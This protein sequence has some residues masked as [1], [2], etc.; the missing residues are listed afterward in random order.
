[1]RREF[2]KATTNVGGSTG[3]IIPR[4]ICKAEGIEKGSVVRIIIE[5]VEQR[6]ANLKE[7]A[8]K[9]SSTTAP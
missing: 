7:E 8:R 6:D 1:M 3:I 4:W 2:E 9:S 5:K